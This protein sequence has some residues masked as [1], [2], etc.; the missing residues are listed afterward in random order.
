MTPK[1]KN[2]PRIT[3][4]TRMGRPLLMAKNP[5]KNPNFYFRCSLRKAMVR[6]QAS[7]V[8]AVFSPRF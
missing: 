3:R 2:K 1:P 5:R 4:M 7:L 6:G 8:A